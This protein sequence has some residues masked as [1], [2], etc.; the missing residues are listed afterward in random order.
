MSLEP[1]TLGYIDDQRVIQLKKNLKENSPKFRGTLKKVKAVIKLL[2]AYRKHDGIE[3]E[4]EF[5]PHSFKDLISDFSGFRAILPEGQNGKTK[6]FA[7]IE[8]IL[9]KELVLKIDSDA[10]KLSS[11]EGSAVEIEVRKIFSAITKEQEF[12]FSRQIDILQSLLPEQVQSVT[13]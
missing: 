5:K 1:R 13:R 2:E 10:K 4:E 6:R 8:A 12:Q 11:I 9:G 3:N 7:G